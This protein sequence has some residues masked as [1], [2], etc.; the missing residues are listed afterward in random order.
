MALTNDQVASYARYGFLTG[1]RVLDEAGAD[2]VRRRFDRLEALVGQ[3]KAQIGL[4][5]RHFEESFIMELAT[6]PAVLDA[7]ES[8]IGPDILLL[9]THFFCK[10]GAGE[11]FVAWHQD[12][13]YWGLEPPNALTI[14]Y[15]VDGS[16]VENG[17][18]RVLP[19]THRDGI[20]AHGKAGVAGN[21]LSINQEVPVTTEEEARAVD[22]ILRPGEASIH[23]GALIHGSLPNRSSRRR[24]GLTMRYVPP[25]VRPVALSSMGTPWRPILVRGEDR[26]GHFEG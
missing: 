10:Y 1:L 6:R 23:D 17:C 14:W 8:L 21:L 12:A 16:D 9:A 11:R 7:V 24:C 26:F 4:V 20:R 19:G 18:M 5:D 25:S 13:T 3:E 22:L 2:E 15:A